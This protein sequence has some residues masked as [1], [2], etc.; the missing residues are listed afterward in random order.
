MKTIDLSIIVPMYNSAQ[1]LKRTLRNL[2]NLVE[3]STQTYQ[4]LL[5]DDGSTDN[6][7]NI[8]EKIATQYTYFEI[9]RRSHEGVS[10]ARNFGLKK[11]NGTYITFVDSDDILNINFWSTIS[12]NFKLGYEIIITD[13]QEKNIYSK[14][15]MRDRVLVWKS[16][17]EKRNGES[18]W[19]KFYKRSFIE[20]NKLKFNEKMIIGEDAMFIYTAITYADS[21]AI[22][23]LPFY[24]Q[25]ETHTLGQFRNEMLASEYVFIESLS[26]LIE[27]YS[28][29]PDFNEL[30]FI[31]NRYKCKEYFRLIRDYFS[32]LCKKKKITLDQA[33]RKL[34]I[35]S[36]KW[37]LKVSLKNNPYSRLY[38]HKRQKLYKLLLVCGSY[39][40]VMVIELFL[41]RFK[42]E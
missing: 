1:Y 2:I 8:A 20:K 21:L 7:L 12:K 30:I 34:K 33:D 41:E 11:A 29:S 24:I 37:E 23:D 3:N 31:L 14:L 15:T 36:K 10:A 40:L 42:K 16:L 38:W 18:P 17:N 25:E 9:F 28:M 22:L 39:K 26:N 32:P 6:T 5:I 4:I 13:R 35:I 27:K 19:S